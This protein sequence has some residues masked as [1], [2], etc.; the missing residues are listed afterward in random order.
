[1]SETDV[2]SREILLY[3]GKDV[4]NFTREQLL[5]CLY[6]LERMR[7]EDAERHTKDIRMMS[8]LGRRS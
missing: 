8:D 6:T 3:R 5:D 2:E 7:R 1:M 4:R